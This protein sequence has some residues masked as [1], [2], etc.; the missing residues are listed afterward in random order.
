MNFSTFKTAVAAQFATMSALQATT[1]FRTDVA[2]DDLWDAYLN[3]FPKGTNPMYRTRT[4]YDCSCCRHFIKSIGNVVAIKNGKLVSIWDIQVDEP[5]FQAVADALSA[6]VKSAPIVDVFLHYERTV[7]TDKTFEQA[8]NNVVTWSHFFLHLPSNVHKQKD[9]IASALSVTRSSHDVLLRSL[10][11]LKVDA[12]QTV[13]ELIAQNSLYRG[14]EHRALLDRFLT[15]KKTYDKATK[16]ARALMAWVWTTEEPHAISHIRN[17]AIGTLLIDLSTDMELETAVK[18]F[19]TVVA[20]ANYKRPTALVTPRMI[21]QAKA[22]IE[23]LGLTSALERR[24]ATARDITADNVLFV[25]RSTQRASADVFDVLATETKA[26]KTKTLDKVEEVSIERFI[27]EVLPCVTSLEVMFENKHAGNLMSLVAPVD[28]TAGALFKWH[29]NYSW[30]YAGDVTDSIKERVKAAGGNVTGDLCCRLAWF[31][32]DDLDLHMHE[33]H[34]RSERAHI[35]FANKSPSETTGRLDVDMNAGYGITRTP[36]ENIYYASHARMK[37]GVYSLSVHSYNKRETKDVG[38][39]VEIDALG[40]VHS[41]VYEKA[42]RTQETVHIANIS[43]TR[44]NIELVGLLP[45]TQA[46]KTKWGLATQSFQRVS[47][48]LTSPN[49]WDNA[50]IGNLHYFFVLD[51]CKCDETPRGFY[52]EFLKNELNAHRKVFEIVGAKMRVPESDTQLSGLGF[53]STQRATLICRVKGAVTRT[54][55]VVF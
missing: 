47:L 40:T 2:R 14:E 35:Y 13:L 23:E 48:A 30:S 8:T 44:D 11:E 20:P 18:R 1:L 45:S 38:F 3:G 31:N 17:S 42:V 9:A 36:V 46:S 5:A 37:P 21:E 10:E 6:L 55:K 52:N 28:P 34:A 29:N 39:E 49:H 32:T 15:L 12:V 22:T 27:K 7:G 53:S 51:G 19:E 25:D 24:H 41:F 54:L 16:S 26:R 50:G 4:E 43:V 33:T